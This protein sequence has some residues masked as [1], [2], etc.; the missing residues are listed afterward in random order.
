MGIKLHVLRAHIVDS[1]PP[2]WQRS[3]AKIHSSETVTE[4]FQLFQ[5]LSM[6]KLTFPAGVGFVHMASFTAVFFRVKCLATLG[7]RDG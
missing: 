4:Q 7:V 2:E 6:S 3:T 5:L 1:V